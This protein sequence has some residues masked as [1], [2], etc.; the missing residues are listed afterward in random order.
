MFRRRYLSGVGTS[1]GSL[2]VAA[3]T[4]GATEH[5]S[6]EIVETNAPVEG[7]SNLEV[8]AE[9][10]NTSNEEVTHDVDLVVGSDQEAVAR[11]TETIPP[12]ETVGIDYFQFRTYP[13]REDDE[14][15]IAVQAGDH[16][17][18]TM[19]EVTGIPELDSAV[20]EPSPEVAVQPG[21]EIMFEVGTSMLADDEQIHW[22]VNG[23]AIDGR[24]SPRPGV[25]R[26]EAERDFLIETF[27]SE[28][29]HEVAAAAITDENA[30]TSWEITVAPDGDVPPSLDA[31]RPETPEV[32][33]E[34][35]YELE[36]DVSS[37]GSD[38]DRVIWWAH[39]APAFVTTA[40]S[41][42]ADTASI[43]GGGVMDDELDV[44]VLT[45][46]N[47][48]STNRAV[49]SF[50]EGASLEDEHEREGDDLRV[51]ITDSND[52][53]TGGDTLEV[54]AA[55]ENT[56][57]EDVTQEVAFIVGEDPEEVDSQTVTITSGET[58]QVTLEFE[59]YPVEEDDLFPARVEAGG[60]TDER[61]VFVEGTG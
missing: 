36:V 3:S 27:D 8:V 41:G 38:L 23:E 16:S 21:T 7:G 19:V 4:V 42:D 31:T 37:S 56:A 17:A 35:E 47:A 44:W 18:E 9:I 54:T 5:L 25:Y 57:T 39:V 28:G 14:F 12:N 43:E 55:L 60:S 22:Y 24:M 30:V 58:E 6:V 45:E 10:E 33:T 29:T 32:P 61:E 53:V 11:R 46:N 52:P 59:T 20:T 34:G 48:L 40:V 26:N 49:W 13:V 2:T 51:A 1:I 50:V 15:P